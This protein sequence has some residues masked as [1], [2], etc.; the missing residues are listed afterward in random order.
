MKGLLRL[1][2]GVAI[3]IVV[4]I[5]LLHLADVLGSFPDYLHSDV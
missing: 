5:F 1:V 3:M 2:L 4:V